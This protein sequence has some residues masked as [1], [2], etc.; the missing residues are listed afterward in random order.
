VIEIRRVQGEEMLDTSVPLRTYAF[1]VTPRTLDLDEVRRGWAYH[2]ET[3][4]LVLFDDGRPMAAASVVPM[5]Q[6]VRGRVL[7][8]A[9]VAGV[10]S[11]PEGRRRGYQRQLLARLLAD[12]AEAGEP[13]SALYPFRESFYE[14]LGYAGL[15]QLRAVTVRPERLGPLLRR[16]LPGSVRLQRI[17]TG[18]DE[19]RG[20]LREMQGTT[21]GMAVR[22]DNNAARMRDRDELWVALA[23]GEDGS[24]AGA[25]T[26]SI[27]GFNEELRAGAMLY[28]GPADRYLLLQWLARHADQVSTAKVL[29]PLSEPVDDWFT[30]LRPDVRTREDYPAPMGRVLS[31]TGLAGIGAGD[32]EFVAT[33]RDVTCP[34][35]EGTYRFRGEGGLLSVEPAA[36]PQEGC[37]LTVAGLS[38]LVYSGYDPAALTFRGWGEVPAALHPSIR[39]VFPPVTPY[40]YEEF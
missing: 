7:P 2:V 25:L 1:D 30:D 3:Y 13:V 35:N 26:Y 33:V 40:V 16:A 9:G 21:H 4:T 14:R 27:T 36:D 32:G 39:A 5:T 22:G 10:A 23:H 20:L 15:P 38:A 29:V 18:F 37:V 6:N 24:T 11:H 17:G 28:R 8:M 31:V 34:W 12:R 19:Y